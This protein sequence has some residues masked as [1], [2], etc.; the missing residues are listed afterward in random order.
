MSLRDLNARQ[1]HAAPAE[2]ARQPFPLPYGGRDRPDLRARDAGALTRRRLTSAY[3]FGLGLVALLT[4]AGALLMGEALR[5][6]ADHIA[7]VH[8]AGLQQLHVQ[9]IAALAGEAG[10]GDPVAL[11]EMEAE[12]QALL[13][14]LRRLRGEALRPGHHHSTLRAVYEG[15]DAPLAAEVERHAARALALRPI[16]EGGRGDVAWLEAQHLRPDGVAPLISRLRAVAELH[17]TDGASE[18]RW[19]KDLHLAIVVLALLLLLLEGLLIFRPLVRRTARLAADLEH[20]ARTDALTGLMNRRAVTQALNG[21]LERGEPLALIAVDLD[22]FKEANDAEG[23]AAGDA[24]LR[25]AGE[26]LRRAVRSTDI[27]GRLGGDEFVAFLPGVREEAQIQAV[28]ERVRRALHE[29]VPHGERR[30][31]LGATLGLAIAPADAHTGEALLRAAD[32]ALV[33]AKREGRGRVGRA[34]P[35]DSARFQR[36]S[37]IAGALSLSPVL[38]GLEVHFQPM[39]DLDTGQVAGLE[40]LARWSHPELGPVRAP[41]LFAVAQRIGRAS[42]L[43]RQVLDLALAGFASL[44]QG[45]CGRLSLN[46]CPAELLAEDLVEG[47]AQRLS[48]AGFGF[49]ALVIEVQEECLSERIAHRSLPALV[50]LRMAGV[51][52][53]LDDFGAGAISLAPLLR[54]RFD[55]VKLDR[56]LVERVAREAPTARFAAGLVGLLDE[57]GAQVVGEGVERASET[58]AL[59]AAGCRLAQGNALAPPMSATELQ[60]WMTGRAG[61][62]RVACA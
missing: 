57:V 42:G 7:M 3:L 31:R 56:A 40:A 13:A 61:Q 41:E 48:C 15:G 39:L 55:M 62:P 25:A 43:G 1:G 34:A 59:R 35:E 60:E 9:R 36:E 46:L 44:P 28:A 51:R 10:G 50:A 22:H 32:A 11:Q 4:V 45:A 53:A 37:A 16:I 52:L 30:L 14:G 23:H 26:R 2:D 54:E 27:V 8:A 6:Q 29:P 58:A 20:E 21:R 38:A 19:A 12:A 5:R 18:T 33:R 17:A 24:L 47:F 49:D